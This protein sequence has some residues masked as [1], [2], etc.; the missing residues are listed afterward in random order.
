MIFL[1]CTACSVQLLQLQEQLLQQR[2]SQAAVTMRSFSH[3]QLSLQLAFIFTL[4]ASRGRNQV[5]VDFT[6]PVSPQPPACQHNSTQADSHLWWELSIY[7]FVSKW[8]HLFPPSAACCAKVRLQIDNPQDIEQGNYW[9]ICPFLFHS[10]RL[11]YRHPNPFWVVFKTKIK[12]TS[13]TNWGM[14]KKGQNPAR[15]PKNG[16][17]SGQTATYRK[18]EVIQSYLRMWGTYDPIESGP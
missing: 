3:F 7:L 16:P 14:A 13:L 9:R 6:E 18:T 1:Q 17:P 4:V 8:F 10:V 5:V 11:I 15:R 2:L 12:G